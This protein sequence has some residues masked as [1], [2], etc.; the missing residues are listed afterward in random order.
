MKSRAASTH[1]SLTV[2]LIVICVL[3][4][5]AIGV[6]WYYILGISTNANRLNAE[7]EN[8][9][10]EASSLS[11][12]KIRLQKVIIDKDTL[13]Q[14]IPDGKDISSFLATFEQLSQ[15]HSIKINSEQVGDTKAKAK[16]GSDFSQAI[17]K[18]QYYELPV[19]YDVS[20]NYSDVQ[21]LLA[22]LQA[23]R[24]LASVTNLV[25]TADYS[26][27]SAPSKVRSTFTV[28]I[29]AKKQ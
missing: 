27:T 18:Q 20:G 26:D 7:T 8:F 19:E 2:S 12:L 4:F 21:V 22:D 24:R 29:Y 5:V 11:T 9:T 14:T 1:L 28:N 25:V 6:G 15:S 3:G 13:L 23:T 17:N 16:T 10:Q